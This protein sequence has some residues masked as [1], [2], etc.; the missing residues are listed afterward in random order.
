MNFPRES[1]QGSISTSEVPSKIESR[2]KEGRYI[3]AFPPTL[4]ILNFETI[5]TPQQGQASAT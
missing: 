4:S 3:R 1:S 5:K 2:Q